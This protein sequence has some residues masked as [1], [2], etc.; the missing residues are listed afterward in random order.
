[1][2]ADPGIQQWYDAIT[3]E[4]RAAGAE[5]T[6]ELRARLREVADRVAAARPEPPPAGPTEDDEVLGF[7]WDE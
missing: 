3:A 6:G 7:Q 5:I 1:M 2:S 4:H